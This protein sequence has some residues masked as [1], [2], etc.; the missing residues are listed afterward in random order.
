M[1]GDHG[2]VGTAPITVMHKLRDELGIAVEKKK[3]KTSRN[4]AK[5]LI[6]MI[7]KVIGQTRI[8]FGKPHFNGLYMV[9]TDHI[10][11]APEKTKEA[12]L[13]FNS[14]LA[15]AKKRVERMK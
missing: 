8:K 15:D 7:P 13:Q 2:S 6:K 3:W 9:G 14:E 10:R 11:G 12:I 5:S 4:R 1:D